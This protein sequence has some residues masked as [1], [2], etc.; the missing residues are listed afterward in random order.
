MSDVDLAFAEKIATR[1]GYTQT[2]YTSS[3]ALIGLYCLRDSASDH[4]P[5][6]CVIKTQECGFLMVSGVEDMGLHDLC[7][8]EMALIREGV[9]K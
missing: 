4:K 3:S 6:A 8:E 9:A 1:K 5:N 2:A 7:A